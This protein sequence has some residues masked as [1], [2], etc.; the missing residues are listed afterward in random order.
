[1]K[2]SNASYFS[3]RNEYLFRK[4]EKYKRACHQQAQEKEKEV[5]HMKKQEVFVILLLLLTVLLPTVL[6]EQQVVVNSKNWQD[7]YSGIIYSRLMGSP[8]NY[9]IEES[10]GLLLIEQGIIDHGLPEVLLIESENEPF[11][12]GYQQRLEIAGYTVEKL[13]SKRGKDTNIKLA[14]RVL[15]ARNDLES[16]ILIDGG[17]GYGAISVGPYAALTNSLVLFAD[18]QNIEE[19]VDFVTEFGKGVLLYG[20]VDREVKNA[21]A[22]RNPQ[23][24]NTGNPTTDNIEM[25]KLFFE[26]NPTKQIYLTDGEYLEPGLISGSYP[27]LLVGSSNVPQQTLEYLQEADVTTAV[28]IGYQLF[29]QAQFIK[30]KTGIRIFLK[31]AQGRDSKLYALDMFPVPKYDT[32]LAIKAVRYNALTR[33]LEVVFENTGEVYAYV[34]TL[35]HNL[36]VDEATVATLGDEE[37]FFLDAGEIKTR[38]YDVDLTAYLEENIIA[39][40]RVT[41]GETAASLTKMFTAENPVEI[42]KEEDNSAIA[43][44]ELFWNKRSKR[45]EISIKNIGPVSV[46]VNPEIIDLIIAGEKVT[47]GGEQRRIEVGGSEVFKIK[48]AELEEEDFEDNHIVKI[49]A[50]YGQREDALLKS[51]TEELP[52]KIKEAD[53]KPLILIG[54]VALVV[55]L[56]LFI[57]KKREEEEE[58]ETH[59]QQQ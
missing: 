1:M 51:I 53:Y 31:Y 33:Q 18:K 16:F 44:E 30:E 27:L 59:H 7:V 21:F 24:I 23:I 2:K 48:A 56:F 39:K 41:Y 4:R 45:F 46:H 14:E 52:F 58:H 10:Q 22:D 49:R 26:K 28:V 12:K 35:D 11:I 6:A 3:S 9:I 55:F 5:N 50:H 42:I 43:F 54:A 32:T 13:S 29:P 19:V 34:Q 47:L 25:V 15:A 38:V 40:S 37:V 17:L 8:L 20:H 36:L 57:R